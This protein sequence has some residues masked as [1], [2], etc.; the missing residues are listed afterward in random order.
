VRIHII[1]GDDIKSLI[2]VIV[3]VKNEEKYIERCLQSLIDQDFCHD[4]YQIV[5]VDGNSNDRTMNIVADYVLN[6]PKLVKFCLNPKEWQAIGRNIVIKKEKD[7]PLIAYVDGHCF[8]DKK[9]LSTLYKSLQISDSNIAGFGSVHISP[10]DESFIGG[11]I[12][13]VFSTAIGGYGS[14]YRSSNLIKEVETASFVLYRR[15]ALERVGLY[16]EDM[17][18]GEDFT[19]N[20]K[21]RMAG[22]KLFVNPEAIIYYYKRETFYSFFKQIYNYGVAKGMIFRKYPSSVKLFNFIPSTFI[23]LLILLGIFGIQELMFKVALFLLIIGYISSIFLFSL[24]KIYEVQ[25]WIL[26]IPIMII[27]II[28]HFGFGIGFIRGLFK[29]GWDR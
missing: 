6:Y 22:Y 14:S 9:W 3:A 13:Q 28:E 5:V 20:Y 11:A 1:Q 29:R 10:K 25:R 26:L 17:K 23:L 12:E 16:D 21:L 2:T 8:A 15:Y 18:I 7:S 27:F 19:L 4:L 24:K